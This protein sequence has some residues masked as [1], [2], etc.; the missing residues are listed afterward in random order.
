MATSGDHN[1]AETLTARITNPHRRAE[2]LAPLAEA[3]AARGDHDRAARL[4]NQ[5]EALT[6]QIIDPYRRAKALARL[7]GVVATGGDRDRA[8]RLVNQAEALTAQITNR[9]QRA[10]ALARLA[11]AVAAS[12]DHNRAETLTARITNP[13]SR[14]WALAQLGWIFMKT[15]KE[16]S[17]VPEHRTP[18]QQ[19][20][21]TVRARHLLA[22]AL[23]TGSWTQIVPGLARV[24][25][26]AISAL[27]D[28]VQVRW[29]LDS[30]DGPQRGR[31]R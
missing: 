19:F 7:A 4:A 28:E 14:V 31:E 8:A 9:N 16:I 1:R 22:A 27:A 24:D 13:D 3:L 21:L 23:V 12:G 30:P 18:P 2:A 25:P 11:K 26:L 15:S 20:A 5:A 10:W 29:G 6:G 17:P